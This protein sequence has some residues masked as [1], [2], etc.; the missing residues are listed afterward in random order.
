MIKNFANLNALWSYLII[1]EL[2]RRGIKNFVISPGSRSTPLVMAVAV[3]P[4]ANKKIHYDERGAAFFALG[5]SKATSKSTVLICTS[6]TAVA[7]YYPAIVEAYQES[8]PLIILS[9]DRPAALRDTGANQT[10][11]QVEIFGKY[12]EMFID[13]PCP[14]ESISP[15]FVLNTVAKLI[16]NIHGPVHMNCMYDEPLAPVKKAFDKK[17]MLPVTEWFSSGRPYTE[18]KKQDQIPVLSEINKFKSEMADAQNGLIIVG[19]LKNQQEKNGVIEFLNLIDWPVFADILSG[20]R[21]EPETKNLINFYDQIL[22][23]EIS[24]PDFVIHIGGRLTSKR[25]LTALKSWSI[26]NYIHVTGDYLNFDPENVVKTRIKCDLT[27]SALYLNNIV[28]PNHTS[29]LLSTLKKKDKIISQLIKSVD[30]LSEIT[31]TREI[32]D[33][34][35]EEH[36]LF[37]ASSMPVRDMEMYAEF[38]S[39]IQYVCSNRG[40]SGIDGTIASAVGFAKG[41]NR[42][43]TLMI[44]DLAFLHDLNSIH[45]ISHSKVPITLIIINNDGGGIF[46]FLP[47]SEFTNE[48]EE[49][50]ATPHNLDFASAAKLFN[51]EYKNPNTLTEFIEILKRSYSQSSRSLIVEIN[52]DRGANYAQHKGLQVDIKKKISV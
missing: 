28:K 51:I 52:S 27:N 41:I 4:A 16:D 29:G 37:L 20:I 43:L 11:N 25:L 32:A 36:G 22:L 1:E 33:F 9:A 40:A 7:N 23:N 21:F 5:L 38:T 13:L 14:D 17:Y 30:D 18:S 3:N 6:G 50:F 19:R 46:S 48:F 15:E 8:V 35:P 31:I 45:M 42:P 10:I 49:Y 24:A 47:I 44:G 34:I 2:I 26:E 39:K 12:T